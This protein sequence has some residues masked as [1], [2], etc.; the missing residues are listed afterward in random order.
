MAY[1]KPSGG[2]ARQ[3]LTVVGAPVIGTN[4][5][6]TLTIGGTP[7]GGTFTLSFQGQATAPIAWSNDNPTLLGAIVG[8]LY[9]IPVLNGNVSVLA[10]TLTAGIGTVTITFIGAL[11]KMAVPTIAVANNSLTGSSPTVAVA[12][13]TPGVNPTGRGAP[14]GTLLT[15]TD[16][17]EL[18][19]NTDIPALPNWVK[20]GTQA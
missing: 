2:Y 7:S 9:E 12:E 13:T 10:G 16:N 17:G 3:G 4:E 11:G 5:V 1:L 19:I 8:A 18:Y 6:Q 15:D 14:T 20:V